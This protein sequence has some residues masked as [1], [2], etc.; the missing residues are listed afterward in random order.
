MLNLI[1]GVLAFFESAH[2]RVA[3][4]EVLEY[5]SYP[6]GVAVKFIGDD[7]LSYLAYQSDLELMRGVKTQRV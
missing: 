7:G 4:V 3:V 5:L 1:E 2:G 6:D